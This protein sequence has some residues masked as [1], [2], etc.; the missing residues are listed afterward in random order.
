MDVGAWVAVGCG[1]ALVVGAIVAIPAMVRDTRRRQAR[2]EGGGAG[3][4]GAGLDA[5]WRPSVEEANQ[6]WKASVEAPAPAPAP[7]DKGLD[8]G[9]IV[10]EVPPDR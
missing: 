7:G 6:E 1:F 4:L 5:V 10:I 2:G 3:G 9:L 8:D